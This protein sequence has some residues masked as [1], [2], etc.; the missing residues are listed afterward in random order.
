MTSKC[1][2]RINAEVRAVITRANGTVEDLG[3]IGYSSSN[4]IKQLAWDLSVW[5]KKHFLNKGK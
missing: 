3:V 2:A 4:P 5:F 1:N